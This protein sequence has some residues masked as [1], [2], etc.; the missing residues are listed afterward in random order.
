MCTDI[1]LRPESNKLLVYAEKYGNVVINGS[2]VGNNLFGKKPKING[3]DY[4]FCE[5]KEEFEFHFSKK[6]RI[7]NCVHASLAVMCYD[8]VMDKIPKDKWDEQYVN[9]LN[10]G[11][12]KSDIEKVATA[13]ILKLIAS[14]DKKILNRV[15][16]SKDT[17]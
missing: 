5:D 4:I 17:G 1:E 13:E 8:K 16:P 2:K 12:I 15:F 11:K 10:D 3:I 6:F 14:T 9:L 7:L